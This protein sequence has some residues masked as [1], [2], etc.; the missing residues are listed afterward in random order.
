MLISIGLGIGLGIALTA[1]E[2]TDK[3][4]TRAVWQPTPGEQWQ[5]VLL[6]AI[7]V[8]AGV[9]PDVPI[10]DIDLYTNTND[11]EDAEHVIGKLH[12]LGKKVICYF[13]AGTYEPDR[14]DS[15]QYADEDLGATLPEWPKERWVDIRNENVRNIIRGRIELA[16]Q[17]GCDGIDPDNMDGYSNQ[18]GGGFN[19]RL[20][21]QDSIDLV[22]MMAEQ[23]RSL[24]MALGLKNALSIIP[25]VVDVVQFAV[26]E[27]C[28][29]YRECAEMQPFIQAGKPVFHIE[30]PEGAGEEGGIPEDVRREHCEA[31]GTDGF[32]TVLKTGD[33]DGW[34]QYCDGSIHETPL[35]S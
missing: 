30:Y 33:L 23:A 10:F 27:E 19:P 17:M 24:N 25:D 7:D 4:A 20:T 26:N 3:V 6:D 15:D 11:G 34:V 29:D 2:P 14:P 31:E 32:S 16:A 13:S 9:T 12:D 21:E 22:N 8:S 18:N 1:A 35:G 5:I 28:A